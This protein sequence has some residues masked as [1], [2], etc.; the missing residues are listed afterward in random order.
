MEHRQG[1]TVT[2]FCFNSKCYLTI[3]AHSGL[4][5]AVGV[6]ILSCVVLTIFV[7]EDVNE[8]CTYIDPI[9]FCTIFVNTMVCA[10]SQKPLF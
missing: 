8:V 10:T 4:A 6:S 1:Y 9:H 2:C 3:F 7:A 5:A